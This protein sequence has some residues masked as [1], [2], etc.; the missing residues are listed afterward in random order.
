MFDPTDEINLKG[1]G[2]N[3]AFGVGDFRSGEVLD[4]PDWVR[5]EVK[6]IYGLN[7]QQLN[8]TFL[9]FH[10]CTDDDYD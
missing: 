4:S 1:I 7:Q 8:F 5:W 3:I 6:L 9:N 10:K 2:F